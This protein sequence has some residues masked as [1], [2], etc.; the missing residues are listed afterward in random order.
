MYFLGLKLT[1]ISGSKPLLCLRCWKSTSSRTSMA[2]AISAPPI[3]DPTM[4]A[5]AWVSSR[6][7]GN[8]KWLK[9]GQPIIQF[10]KLHRRHSDLLATGRACN[11]PRNWD[12]Y[13]SWRCFLPEKPRAEFKLQQFIQ[14]RVLWMGKINTDK[15]KRPFFHLIWP[16]LWMI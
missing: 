14:I 11:T 8:M 12:T 7:P 4:T 1:F 3:V 15:T 10:F 2:R 5:H 9:W 6:E 13:Q 16:K